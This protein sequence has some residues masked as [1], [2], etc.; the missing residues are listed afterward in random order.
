MADQEHS[1]QPCDNH[2]FTRTAIWNIPLYSL[3]AICLLSTIPLLY[4]FI[5]KQRIENKK[6]KA[7]KS[8]KC[9]IFSFITFN[10]SAL[11]LSL[12]LYTTHC[13]NTRYYI[14]EILA[15][16][17]ISCYFIQSY[18]LLLLSFIRLHAIF[19]GTSFA[20]SRR[21]IRLFACL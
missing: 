11:I 8:F 17:Y 18:L 1:E 6:L 9:S 2:Y 14:T 10:I 16:L 15:S 20:S 12:I 4:Y 7:P 13:D 3:N 19:N 21:T 5:Q